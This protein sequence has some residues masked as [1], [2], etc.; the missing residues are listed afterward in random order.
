M[1]GYHQI[2]K[3][4]DEEKGW[5]GLYY[6]VVS[7]VI[8][9]NGFKRCAEI[10]I[11][12]GQHALEILK[13]T[14]VETLYLVDPLKFYE[15]DDF[16]KDVLKHIGSFDS[17]ASS[18]K[19]TLKPYED[20]YTWFRQSST[21][22]S[23]SQI[24]DESLDLV[25]IDADHS[26][27]AVSADLCFWWNKVKSGGFILGDDYASCHPG[28]KKAVDDF[29]KERELKIEFLTK[30]SKTSYPIYKIVKS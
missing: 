26:Y 4:H 16:P 22:I 27:A 5:A 21:S 28:T 29:V 15:G 19:D 23:N 7:K 10:G 2:K 11:G 24:P 12:Y 18:I 17:L 20:R 13:N 9:E 25:F 8:N 30:N 1:K 14:K 3:D 6:G